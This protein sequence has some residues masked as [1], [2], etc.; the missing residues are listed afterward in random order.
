M[1]KRRKR[2][3]YPFEQL[4]SNSKRFKNE[5][6]LHHDDENSIPENKILYGREKE[7]A[8]LQKLLHKG[9]VSQS[10]ASIFVSGPPGTGKTLAIKTVLRNMLLQ[11]NIH[12]IYINCASENTER[13]ILAVILNTY[14]KCSKRLCGKKLIMEFHKMLM[15]M[16]EHIILVLDEID[17][18]RSKDRDSLCSMFQWPFLY[19]SVSL[20]G[21][22]N[23]LDV[24]ELL[25][26]KLK[27]IPELIIFAP[28]SEVQLH[29]I[30][31]K[32]LK[33]NDGSAIEL[34]AR[35]VAAITGDARKAVQVMRRSLSINLSDENTFRNVFGTLTRVYGSPMLQA[36]IPL[37]QKILL[38]V[39]L[40][41]AG[42]N[43]S[44]TVEK[45]CLLS[46]YKKLCEYLSLPALEMD[47]MHEA[48]SLL[49]SQSILKLKSSSYQLLVDK[50]AAGKLIADSSLI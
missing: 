36:K 18:V 29:R 13:D 33:I 26:H 44:I 35:K 43:P 28:Y 10:P 19:S 47:E 25:K 12:S 49:E 32:K 34:C 46:T 45:G 50:A 17:Y 37:Q 21:I 27:S 11:N 42:D 2:S 9:I 48:L 20:I 22:S 23:T 7:V 6:I 16:N 31:S 38:A 14:N 24:M 4:P 41:L 30:L 15:K 3:E 8:L 1:A 40:R 5:L 39:M